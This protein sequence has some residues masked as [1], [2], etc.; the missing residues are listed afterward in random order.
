MAR[1]A[2]PDLEALAE[3][4]K[5]GSPAALEK[6]LFEVE[7]RASSKP[8]PY[9]RYPGYDIFEAWSVLCSDA[10]RRGDGSLVKQTLPVFLSALEKYP[11][12]LPHSMDAAYL[13][14]EEGIEFLVECIRIGLSAVTARGI[15]ALDKGVSHSSAE[16]LRLLESALS[17][18]YKGVNADAQ[19][20]AILKDAAEEFRRRLD[21]MKWADHNLF[22]LFRVMSEG[23]VKTL[24][25]SAFTATAFLPLV[26]KAEGEGA[27][28]LAELFARAGHTI[29]ERAVNPATLDAFPFEVMDA[30]ALIDLWGVKDL[31]DLGR[32]LS[33][34]EISR[35]ERALGVEIP[36]DLR[37]AWTEFSHVGEV[38]FGPPARMLELRSEMQEMLAEHLKESPALEQTDRYRDVRHY[39]PMEKGIPLGTDASGDIFFLATN[40]ESQTGHMPVIRFHHGEALTSSVAASSLGEYLAM[41][42]AEPFARREGLTGERFALMERPRKV[43][44]ESG[45]ERD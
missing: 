3:A 2:K 17:R 24:L 8:G 25:P 23:Y 37:L 18:V 13:L 34:R 38:W 28:K 26:L 40:A 41:E 42:I 44:I 6:M 32:G 29:G 12:I 16:G 22:T 39:E 14:R 10:Y 1:K 5:D 33:Q 35:F 11:Y 31:L 21:Q 15:A 7:E 4:A 27:R 43:I 45:Q 36:E 20:N 30:L 19:E 9:D